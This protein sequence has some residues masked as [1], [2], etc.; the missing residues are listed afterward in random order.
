MAVPR[1]RLPKRSETLPAHDGAAFDAAMD[2]IEGRLRQL[3]RVA[4]NE[5][6]R[7][8]LQE[9]PRVRRLLRLAA[10]LENIRQ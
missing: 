1:K 3:R 7:E 6:A 9:R 8:K 5:A 4:I 2:V 10:K